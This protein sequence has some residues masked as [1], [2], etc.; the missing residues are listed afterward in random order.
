VN[1]GALYVQERGNI[2]GSNDITKPDGH[3][4]QSYTNY[5]LRSLPTKMQSH[6]KERFIKFIVGWKKR[7]YETIPDEA[8][9]QLEVKCWAPSWKRMARCILRNDYYCK[10]LGQTQPKSEAY[11]KY[12]QIKEKRKIEANLPTEL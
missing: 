2:N 10:G 8:P 12:K 11:E 1:S 6:Y 7:G 3:T 4:W 9:H 5:L